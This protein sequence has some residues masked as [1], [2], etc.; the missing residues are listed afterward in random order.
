MGRLWQLGQTLPEHLKLF[1]GRKD[2]ELVLLDYNSP[3]GLEEWIKEDNR[4]I[5]AI[6]NGLL[7]YV[8]EHSATHFHCSKAKNLAH[9]M[10]RGEILV[11]LDSDNWADAMDKPI[12]MAFAESNGLIF[13]AYNQTSGD[14]TCGRVAVARKW[15]YRLG[16]YD[17]SF[18]PMGYQDI[19]FVNRASAAGLRKVTFADGRNPIA[20]SVAQKLL[21]TGSQ[22]RHQAMS[23]Q[24]S[25]AS[26][27]RLNRC[28]WMANQSGWGAGKISRN[29]GPVHVLAAEIPVLDS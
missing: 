9:R 8:K 10:A 29:F 22:L 26:I 27:D 2:V 24:N 3:D 15:F 11:N 13:H 19:D 1:H 14:G 18:Q 12:R 7:V 20:N 5:D 4:A 16:G 23:E 21:F 6:H 28:E 17:E 25:R